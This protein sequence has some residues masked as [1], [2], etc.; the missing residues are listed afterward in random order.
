M[1]CQY[2]GVRSSGDPGWGCL[3][4]GIRFWWKKAGEET[5]K[6]EDVPKCMKRFALATGGAFSLGQWAYDDKF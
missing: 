3:P 6:T 2:M 5:E 1:V 4:Y